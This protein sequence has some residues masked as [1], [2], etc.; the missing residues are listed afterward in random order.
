MTQQK[1]NDPF[2]ETLIEK[3]A[4][5]EGVPENE[6]K[7]IARQETG[8][9]GLDPNAKSPAGARGSLQVMPGTAR[10]HVSPDLFETA[11]GQIEAGVKE[12][13]RV[14]EKYGARLAP[15]AYHGGDGA[16]NNPKSYDRYAN[17]S[18][19][20]YQANVLRYAGIDNAEDDDPFASFLNEKQ[21]SDNSSQ[22]SDPFADFLNEKQAESSATSFTPNPLRGSTPKRGMQPDEGTAGYAESPKPVKG[23]L[24]KFKYRPELEEQ[25]ETL[26]KSG[27]LD[28]ARKVGEQLKGFGYE[29]DQDAFGNPY[30]KRPD[31]FVIKQNTGPG[32]ST[33]LLDRRSIPQKLRDAQAQTPM[34]TRIANEVAAR[35]DKKNKGQSEY[36]A[37]NGTL[38]SEVDEAA[39]E[40]EGRAGF[41]RSRLEALAR[42]TPQEKQAAIARITAERPMTDDERV[43][44]GAERGIIERGIADIATGATGAVGSIL[45]GYRKLSQTVPTLFDP[46]GGV[47]RAIGMEAPADY[48]GQAGEYL[49]EAAKQVRNAKGGQDIVD[50]VF[51]G[52]GSTLPYLGG[53]MLGTPAVGAMGMFGNA[54]SVY[55]EAIESGADEQTARKAAMMAAPVGIL[56]AFGVGGT[57][58][59]I[60][61]SAVKGFIKKI[62]YEMGEEGTQEATNQAFNN[63]IAKGIY[64]PQRGVLKDVA[65]NAF[66]GAV[67][68]GL[69]G[70]ASHAIATGVDKLA[71]QERSGVQNPQS[72]IRNPQSIHNTPLTEKIQPGQVAS[73]V[74]QHLNV[75]MQQVE[76]AEAKRQAVQA[77]A[78]PPVPETP[79]T[80]NAQLQ[81]LTE[82]RRSAVLITPGEQ[83][84]EVPQGFGTTQ[85]DAGVFIHSP[86][87]APSEIQQMVADNTFGELLGHVAPKPQP[88][89]PSVTV[90]ARDLQGSEVQTSVVPP[91]LAEQQVQSLQ[92]QF[93]DAQIEIGGDKTTANILN[94]RIKGD[95]QDDLLQVSGENSNQRT[96]STRQDSE[97][98]GVVAQALGETGG[99]KYS[100]ERVEGQEANGNYF[101]DFAKGE[102]VTHP[103]IA[104]GREL[105][106]VNVSNSGRNLELKRKDGKGNV[107][108]LLADSPQGKGLQRVESTQSQID[109][110]A[111]EAATSP[112]NDLPEPTEGQIEAGNYKKGHARVGGLD[113]SI[114][115]PAGSKRRPEWPTL[116]SHYGYIRRTEGADGEHIDVFVKEGTPED[117]SGAVFVVDQ[118]NK[119]GS[120]DEHKVLLGFDSRE[121][122]IAGYRENFTKD[123]KVGPVREFQSVAEFRDWLKDG[124]TTKPANPVPTSNIAASNIPAS[125]TDDTYSRVVEFANAGNQVTPSSLQRMLHLGYGEITRIIGRLKAEGIIDK[126]GYKTKEKIDA[127]TRTGNSADHVGNSAT[128]VAAAN[129]PDRETKSRAEQTR[130]AIAK[131][132]AER[133]KAVEPE[134]SVDTTNQIPE[135]ETPEQKRKRIAAELKAEFQ[136]AKSSGQS[137]A[138][139]VSS[140]YELRP[141]EGDKSRRLAEAALRDI[142]ESADRA[143]S[144]ND[145]RT[146]EGSQRESTS[147]VRRRLLSIAGEIER[148]AVD[149]RGRTVQSAADIAEMAQV[150]RDPRI[151]TFRIIYTKDNTIVAHEGVS[152]RLPGANTAF[153]FDKH[154]LQKSRELEQKIKHAKS[155]AELNALRRERFNVHTASIKRQLYQMRERMKRLDADGYYLL[156]NHPSGYSHPSQDD[157]V[158]TSIISA[159]V[160]GFQGHVVINSNEYSEIT[161]GVDEEG[162]PSPSA[163][164][165]EV[166][167]G[168]DKLLTPS[169]PGPLANVFIKEGDSN[170]IAAIGQWLKSPDGYVAILYRSSVGELRAIEEIPVGLFNRKKEA[171]DFIRGRQREFG[172][173]DA[174]AYA[175]DD[176]LY[177]QGID[178]MMDGVLS[179]MVT[180]N[181]GARREDIMPAK[182]QLDK[183]G[184]LPGFRVS[185]SE[186]PLPPKIK[187]GLTEIARSFIEEGR[188][189][190]DALI[191]E[192]E[193]L[194]GEEMFDAVA[195]FLPG[196]VEAAEAEFNKGDLQDIE[197]GD[198]SFDFGENIEPINEQLSGDLSIEEPVSA[199]E[200]NVV[201]SADETVDNNDQ[202]EV[203]EDVKPRNN[204]RNQKKVQQ[205]E[206][207]LFDGL[208]TDD[209]DVLAGEQER[210]VRPAPQSR[211]AET[212]GDN[213]AGRDQRESSRP[214][215]NRDTSAHRTERRDDGSSTEQPADETAR[216][217]N[218][219]LSSDY[220]LNP[221]QQLA[222]GAKT[223]FRANVDAI[224]LLK[225]L[226]DEGRI[227]SKA[228]TTEEQAILASYTGWGQMKGAFNTYTDA[229]DWTKERDTLLKLVEDGFLTQEE[230]DSA[231]A[232]TL[233]A[234]YTAPVIVQ[235]MWGIV[236]RLGFRG[237]RTLEPAVGTGNFFG[238]MPAALKTGSHLSGI[239]LDRITANIAQ[240]LYPSATIKQSGFEKVALPDDYF[241]LVISN[242]PFADITIRS[243]R[244]FSDLKPNLHDYFFLKSLDKVKPG[245]LVVAITSTGTL[246]KQNSRIRESL[247]KQADLVAA[248]RLP[249]GT[250]QKNAGTAVVTDLIILRKRMPGEAPNGIAWTNLGEMKT[251][252]G[253]MRPINEYYAAHPEMVLGTFDTKSRMYGNDDSHVTITDDFDD[254]F[255][256]AINQLP[257][258]I[259]SR[260]TGKE[261]AEPERIMVQPGEVKESGYTMRNG[262]LY[263]N[264]QGELK[265]VEITGAPLKRVEGMLGVR[266]A[267]R[268]V[269]NADLAKEQTKAQLARLR[270][271]RV[272]DAFVKKHGFLHA[273]PNLVAFADDP[274]LPILL[275][276]EDYDR[277]AKTATKTD[278]FEKS[279]TRSYERPTS[280]KDPAKALGITLNERGRV[281]VERIAELTGLDSKAVEKMFVDTGLAFL[282]PAQGWQQK[283]IYLSGNVRQ[284]LETARAAAE[285]D[286]RYLTNVEAL[287]KV[288]P[289]DVPFNDIDIKMNSPALEPQDIQ[290]FLAHILQNDAKPEDFRV[291]YQRSMGSWSAGFASDRSP[292][293]NSVEA[294]TVWATNR[295][296]FVE[297]VKAALDDRAIV[298]RD[299]IERN[300]DKYQLNAE[301]TN[302]SNLK[303]RELKNAFS[304]WIWQDDERR[305]R[306]SRKY[307]DTFNNFRLLKYDG[308]HLTFPGMTSQMYGSAF[309]MRPHQKDAVWR[310]ITTGKA[311][312][313]HEVGSG[314]TFTMIAAAMELKRMGLAKKPSIA[315]PK[316]IIHQFVKDAKRLYPGIKILTT[317]D[318]FDEK[319][320][321]Q[322]MSRI[323]TG[324]WDLVIFS[325]EHLDY[326]PVK[327][328]IEE[329]FI[330]EQI[331]ELEDVIEQMKLDD[332]NNRIV[333]SMERRR[334]NLQERQTALLQ[335]T[336]LDDALTFEE[337]G[338]DQ[339]FIDEAHN[340]KS[341]PVFTRKGNILGIPSGDGS[342]RAQ[343]LYMRAR[344]LHDQTGGRGLVLATGTPISNTLVELFTMQRYLQ[345]YEL[346][347]QDISA[348]DAWANMFGDTVTTAEYKP[349]GEWEMV[350]RFARFQNVPEI[351]QLAYQVMDVKLIEDMNWIKRPARADSVLESPM[352]PLQEAFLEQIAD[353]IRAMKKRTGRVTKGMDNMLSVS[354]DARK[355]SLDMRLVSPNAPDDPKGKVSQVANNVLKIWK[356]NPGTTQMIFSDMGVHPNDWGFS[357]YDDLKRKL[358]EGGMPADKIELF[359][360]L[361]DVKKEAA[362]HRL[363]T[364]QST[365]AI[366]GSQTLGTG[367]NAQDNLIALHHIDVPWI[368]AFIEQRDGRGWRQ[369]NKNEKVLIFR[370]VTSGSFDTQ[371]WQTVDRKSQ[372]IGQIMRG[373]KL[374][375]RLAME[376][377]ETMSYVEVMAVASG[378]PALIEM[379]TLKK[380]IEDLEAMRKRHFAQEAELKDRV[381]RERRFIEFLNQEKELAKK[382][383]EQFESFKDADFEMKVGNRSFSNR[384][385]AN[386]ALTTEG[387]F[388]QKDYIF[389]RQ[390]A[391]YKGFTISTSAGSS[392]PSYLLKG[393]RTYDIK[394]SATSIDA[395][396]RKARDFGATADQKIEASEKIIV[397][398]E[399]KMGQPF[400]KDN[401][402]AEKKTR[403]VEVEAEVRR[404]SA[405]QAKKRSLVRVGDSFYFDGRM[406]ELQKLDPIV[407]RDVETGETTTWESVEKFSNDVKKVPVTDEEFNRII[408]EVLNPSTTVAADVETDLDEPDVAGM[409]AEFGM[410]GD[411]QGSP[412]GRKPKSLSE[413]VR[414]KG[415]IKDDGSGEVRRFSNRESASS[416]L[417]TKNGV[418]ADTLREMAVESDYLDSESEE[419][420]FVNDFL[421][422]VLDD[423]TDVRKIYSG[424]DRDY[425]DSLNDNEYEN[426]LKETLS[427][428]EWEQYQKEKADANRT[429]EIEDIQREFAGGREFPLSTKAVDGYTKGK[430]SS[431]DVI[432]SYEKVMRAAGSA[433]PIRTGR[434]NTRKNQ[435]IFKTV[436]NVVR[437]KVANDI[438]TAAHEIGHA[439]QK[440]ILKSVKAS[441]FRPL[442]PE[443][444]KELSRLGKALYGERQPSGG[445]TVEG[446]AEFMRY[447]L[448]RDDA[449]KVAPKTY[450]WVTQTLLPD[451]PKVEKA[452]ADARTLTDTYRK[453]GASNRADANLVKGKTARQIFDTWLNKAKVLPTLMIDEFTP[454]IRLTEQV[455]KSIN[456]TLAAAKNPYKVAAFLRGGAPA[457]TQ[458]MVWDGMVDFARNKV[459]SPLA[460]A[461]AIVK[462]R[463][464]DFTRYLW[465]KR[466]LER[467][468]KGKNPGMT[469][470]DARAIVDDLDSPEF[471]LAASKVYEWNEGILNYVKE[472][473]PSLSNAVDTIKA[474]SENYVPLMRAIDDMD[475]KLNKG[476]G[477]NGSGKV[478]AGMKGSGRRVM[479]IFPAMIANAEQMISKAHRRRVLDTIIGLA[480]HDD[481]GHLIEE[482]PRDK[483]PAEVRVSEIAKQL[484]RA[485]ADLSGVD[486]DEAL[487]FFAPAYFPKGQDPIIPIVV[488]G[489][490]K[491]FQ[492]SAEL[493]ET[494]NGLDLYRLG[495]LADLLL[496]KLSRTFRLG[497]TGLQAGFSLVTNL[498]R[499]VQ[500]FALQSQS[501]NPVEKAGAYLQAM[502][503]AIDPRRIAG[504]RA[505]SLDLFY[506][507]GANMAQPLGQDINV[508]RRAANELFHGM[509]RRIVTH[510][511]EALRDLFSVTE[512]VPRVA[513]LQL[514]AKEIGWDMKDQL[515]IDQAIQLGIAA[516]TVTVDFTAAGKLVKVWNQ[517]IPFLNAN[518]QGTRYFAKA[519]KENPRSATLQAFIY[520]TLPTLFLWWENKDEEWYKDMPAKEKYRY[521]F[522]KAGNQIIQIPRSFEW[523][524]IFATLP[525]ALF[526][527]AYQKDPERLTGALGQVLSNTLPPVLP[528]GL[529]VAKEQ[530][531]NEV[532]FSGR[533][534]VPRSQVDLPRGD[535]RNEYTSQ[536]ALW[537]G[538]AFP[539]HI[540]PARVDHLVRAIGGGAATDL[541]QF[542]DLVTGKDKKKKEWE[543]S[544]LPVAGRLFRRGGT[545]G[546]SSK[547]MEKFYDEYTLALGRQKSTITPET[548]QQKRYREELDDAARAIKLLREAAAEI[549]G[550]E[551]RNKIQL[552]MRR[553][554]EISVKQTGRIGLGVTTLTP[555]DED[556]RIKVDAEMFRLGIHQTLP[557][558]DATVAKQKIKLTPEELKTYRQDRIGREYQ[559]A[560]Q[561]I[562]TPGYKQLNDLEKADTLKKYMDAHGGLEADRMRSKASEKME[563]DPLSKI[564]IKK[565]ELGARK[566]EAELSNPDIFVRT[567]EMKNRLRPLS[568]RN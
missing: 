296:S 173:A 192:F 557:D 340:Y 1:K 206:P 549:P 505:G 382:D 414:S 466:S 39:L 348:F 55:R 255:T 559:A 197:E 52:A 127:N 13:K 249:E 186:I 508:S 56:E 334:L 137:D 99:T 29:V 203:K 143:T 533:P 103:S 230:Y 351:L 358:V 163:K 384:D 478:F 527:A 330:K 211:S 256:A 298:V 454:L 104:G 403:F 460:D 546:G 402:L 411:V 513:E 78:Q 379:V 262:K 507:L 392:E 395:V 423:L 285:L 59:R 8:F 174:V 393:N 14:R 381:H 267:L 228:V 216:R 524:N 304:E 345:H 360:D 64:D 367:V 107:M 273:R 202:S 377:G 331:N 297:I 263:Q 315:V 69:I 487:T 320:R 165:H 177:D 161:M 354:N 21:G 350:T 204:R 114:E 154:T 561:L 440:A 157:L 510:P 88:G 341:L 502:A 207:T 558:D 347:S 539:N 301:E 253:E 96:P 164:T 291:S 125:S 33:Q 98:Q 102:V 333:A 525:E 106:I 83:M 236:E 168:K 81:A 371:M 465:A 258:N 260:E 556:V 90:A 188:T 151:E 312:L 208:R 221:E 446:F 51:A 62:F 387:F 72:A 44:L 416:G 166:D 290:E 79:S 101:S 250:F 142:E 141:G 470:E 313:A 35:R 388:A 80:I 391:T 430:V 464:E 293:K 405:I 349:N 132:R 496:G 34:G 369:G 509:T 516:K 241:D 257:Q 68:G 247:A 118:V 63:L 537:L 404:V 126:T 3:H 318:S 552:Q 504:H 555:I 150:Y 49:N 160:D 191:L 346:A 321:K 547:A 472:A 133:A 449:Q 431:T 471:Q 279:T 30:Q 278:I 87:I 394:P 268:E 138:G 373:D 467:W 170:Q 196:I 231:R 519:L 401:E 538:D 523:S 239:D 376:D 46:L 531:H 183:E 11:E 67:T 167:F 456:N 305:R 564:E 540:S 450:A 295:S 443:I 176:E 220:I 162:Y 425:F 270:L 38:P 73:E 567:Q 362:A 135:N 468:S 415:G 389:N 111:H 31:G 286:P 252:E 501:K 451:N 551:A 383:F 400:T 380:E 372:F 437:L 311:M 16:V 57:A 422:A 224:K 277:T 100:D 36:F 210:D 171:A 19:D 124:D 47:Q 344:Y 109:A 317:A 428:E 322:T 522:I 447:F 565:A 475:D 42:L 58:G 25:F 121:A 54:G 269:I 156:H 489:K 169:V 338:I 352:N 409:P 308:S 378:N 307:N 53:G 469:L 457:V 76:Q 187:S 265:P 172:A 461:A 155:N 282:D 244:K 314:K 491:W 453:E 482:V 458:Y 130:E 97:S 514:M 48:A 205:S 553:I 20:Q 24:K 370:N 185:D 32:V 159:G 92:N 480:E 226:Q 259:V 5:K 310:I 323:A 397:S 189:D 84:P 319:K 532:D 420:K 181:E 444:K 93:P 566:K 184:L 66:I 233:N 178:L 455:E 95:K 27:N 534:I 144:A 412:S 113:I 288:Q 518:I 219:A 272:Y 229:G 179:D 243:D 26:K 303:V 306:V 356:E 433:A 136:R 535:Q 526:D 439:L 368:P 28:E 407:G 342:Q 195:D 60:E 353:R 12:Y 435:G 193:D 335:N 528:H 123:W 6:I 494:L 242:F 110:A 357:V 280:E 2:A 149:L 10:R 246:D 248:M 190:F 284:K 223:K 218:S 300:P 329:Q 543:P 419:G 128:D 122:A 432:K 511:V 283:E 238:L 45:E 237:G 82:G 366:G 445:Y 152:S 434:F 426:H 364:G 43:A 493:Y 71:E 289:E 495:W 266:D 408:D 429:A 212:G 477:G 396:L 479:D 545:V 462:G 365:V 486:L 418:S 421:D 328:E 427:P 140:S 120:F 548:P 134:A 337:T 386:K 180:S 499:D 274:D 235:K 299:L 355:M 424:E 70:G 568:P 542:V 199:A 309:E 158:T 521:W 563:L 117:Y 399:S 17:I 488:D 374:G 544:D 492:V 77:A 217:R 74:D 147:G 336:K 485:G 89:E 146:D 529:Q 50:D 452:I 129:P 560:S 385:E 550:T 325:H 264:H 153:L 363:K 436:A 131:R 41:M 275:A 37:A 91:E 390:I 503:T 232:S 324:D 61:S 484:E 498:A 200:K 86:H 410:P 222:G 254:R 112:V 15:R 115:N 473:V 261:S 213:L 7:A 225:T 476:K 339:L 9:L 359:R 119:D 448:T 22:D 332:V 105:E 215:R 65:Y 441:A 343:K 413:W 481:V 139:R 530:Y 245:G 40:R 271:N 240:A 182:N 417:V 227:A 375:R 512:S 517:V 209:P 276:L 497:T 316:A 554:A 94:D 194:L 251:A 483:V 294:K 536:I 4:A 18:T 287:E 327:P 506:R 75:I 474:S 85:T 520:L 175:S 108:K 234:H 326:L 292:L 406:F 23:N 201:E 438:P 145:P 442:T 459:G 562:D 214:D 148:Q 302:N 515:T 116:K 463:K 490:P 541:S 500:T 361:S 281:D 398:A 198:D